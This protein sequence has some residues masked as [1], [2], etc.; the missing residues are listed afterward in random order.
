MFDDQTESVLAPTGTPFALAYERLVEELENA[1][2]QDGA[3]N[4]SAAYEE[5]TNAYA[6]ALA[7]PMI[8]QRVVTALQQLTDALT[9]AL[10]RPGAR[11]AA[12]E[13]VAHYLRDIGTA[14]P[15]LRGDSGALDSIA[16]VASGM[17]T[18]AWLQGLGASGLMGPFGATT[19]FQTTPSAAADAT[20]GPAWGEPDPFTPS[21]DDDGIVWQELSVGDDGQIVQRPVNPASAG[22]TP[23]PPPTPEAHPGPQGDPVRLVRDAYDAYRRTANGAAAPAAGKRSELEQRSTELT[24]AYLRL[25]QGVGS[26]PELFLTYARFL[27]SASELVEQELELVRT[28]E[29]LVTP[30]LQRSRAAQHQAPADEEYGRFV[31]AVRDAWAQ[32]DPASLTPEQLSEL[33]ELTAKAAAM[34][35]SNSTGGLR[36]MPG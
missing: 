32:T 9:Q 35:D 13:A 12:D 19:L 7:D 23:P 5:Y 2:W 33:A 4:V 14:W 15:E 6:E 25:A 11:T 21:V 27:G 29:R 8:Y 20:N 3:G 36:H 30:T 22:G 26:V 10:A 28:Y 1:L 34:N 18:I 16:A 24:A 31:A 17:V